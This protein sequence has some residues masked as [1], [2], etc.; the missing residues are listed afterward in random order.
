MG[1]KNI[2]LFVNRKKDKE[3]KITGKL[4]N[5]ILKYGMTPLLPRSISD[6]LGLRE[7]YTES[8][9]LGMSSF[10]ISIGGD[11]T[12]L[13]MA[14]T[15]YSHDIPLFGINLGTVGF[16]ADVEINEIEKAVKRLADEDFEIK[17]RMVLSATVFRDNSAV[18]EG[19]AI[20]DAVVNRDG[21]SR[22]I[23]LHVFVDDQFV[24]SFP[25]DGVIV[26]TPTGS[27]AYNLS[28]GGPIVQPD[29]EMMITTPIC[30]HILY[31]RSFITSPDRKLRI[32]INDDYADS[33]ILTMDGQEGFR[34][35]AGD[36]IVVTRAP[37][38]IKFVS[39]KDINFFDVLRA[40]I[41]DPVLKPIH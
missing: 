16:L 7:G 28:A 38:D 18:F 19:I 12:L 33:A 3:L 29:M 1:R 11:G 14:R 40:K 25:G 20:N 26:S 4:V 15:S 8:E 39:F 36:E 35:A 5:L 6:D 34:V 10:L 13:N 31:S 32:I 24:D 23:R 17:N 21:L 41:H 37:K 9:M 30:P 2:G 22:I 27:T